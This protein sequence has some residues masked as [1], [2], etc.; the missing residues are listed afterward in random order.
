MLVNIFKSD[1]YN[2]WAL[3]AITPHLGPDYMRFG[4]PRW[5]SARY[6]MKRA[7][8]VDGWYDEPRETGKSLILVRRRANEPG[9]PGKRSVSRDLG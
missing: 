7:S 2:F 5:L 8:P 1:R 6:Y 4:V 9:W 3:L